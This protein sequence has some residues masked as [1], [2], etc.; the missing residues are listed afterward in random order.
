VD[1]FLAPPVTH[2]LLELE[3]RGS[4]SRHLHFHVSCL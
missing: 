1:T 2:E 3:M 4:G